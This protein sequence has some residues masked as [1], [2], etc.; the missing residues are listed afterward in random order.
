MVVNMHNQ[1]TLI[2]CEVNRLWWLL[3]ITYGMAFISSGFD[4]LYP[5]FVDWSAQGMPLFLQSM[6]ISQQSLVYIRGGLEIIIG[7]LLLTPSVSLAAYIAMAWLALSAA[8]VVMVPGHVD[9]AARYGVIALG[10]LTLAR[11]TKIRDRV[12]SL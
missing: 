4:K 11:L 9:T 5:I 6:G 10:A 7:L 2:F 1:K 8:Y 3:R 12:R